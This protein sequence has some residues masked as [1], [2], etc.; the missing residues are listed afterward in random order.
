MGGQR[1][2]AKPL[3]YLIVTVGCILAMVTAL[4]PLPTGSYKLSG[5]FLVLGI[6]PYIVYGTFT[7]LLQSCTL[8]SAGLVL[9]AVDFLAR[10]GAQIVHVAHA[11]AMPALYL[12]LV[13]TFLVFPVGAALGHLIAKFWPW[14]TQ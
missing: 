2:I 14:E 7:E 4:A 6:I 10:F 12:C 3:A 9:L 1:E 5:V 11:N 13:L 8:I